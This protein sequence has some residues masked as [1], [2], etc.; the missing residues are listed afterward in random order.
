MGRGHQRQGLPSPWTGLGL[1]VN[2]STPSPA[3]A[4]PLLRYLQPPPLFEGKYLGV[5]CDVRL[6]EPMAGCSGGHAPKS[7]AARRRPGQ[8]LRGRSART[9]ADSH[10]AHVTGAGS[11][12]ES[13]SKEQVTETELR[14]AGGRCWHLWAG[15]IG[16]G[17]RAA[18]QP[19]LAVHLGLPF[20]FSRLLP[21]F[22]VIPRRGSGL[23]AGVLAEKLHLPEFPRRPQ[24]CDHAVATVLTTLSI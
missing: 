10:F 14:R 13:L 11:K 4:A 20:A 22:L 23:G 21:S 18:I 19:R 1:A 2:P 16:P 5:R 17:G 15:R 6:P 24:A 9:G 7:G 8:C 3:P 12:R